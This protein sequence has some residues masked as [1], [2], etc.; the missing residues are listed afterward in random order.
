MPR[1][2]YR[3]MYLRILG[4]EDLRIEDV[5]K[6]I[7]ALQDPHILKS[8]YP[9]I[10]AL[11][12][13]LVH[14]LRIDDVARLSARRTASWRAAAGAGIAAGRAASTA[15]RLL[16]V[17]GFGRLVLRGRQLI[18]RRLYRRRVAALRGLLDRLHGRFDGLFV[19]G[20]QLV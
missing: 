2:M 3:S 6:W 12:F 14:D 10:R 18:E 8:S 9:Q 15:G 5:R 19:A 11:L 7:A 13:P 1:M 16:L 4:F 20:A 17:Q